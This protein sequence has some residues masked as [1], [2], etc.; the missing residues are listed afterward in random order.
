MK[1]ESRWKTVGMRKS[2]AC[3]ARFLKLADECFSAKNFAEHF[4]R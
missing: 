2:D 1:A 3:S 4:R